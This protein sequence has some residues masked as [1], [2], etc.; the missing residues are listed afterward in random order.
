MKLPENKRSDLLTDKV[1]S[2]L[3]NLILHMQTC[4]SG[5]LNQRFNSCS[6]QEKKRL[7]VIIGLLSSILL[8][9]GSFCSLYTI[10]KLS[11]NYSS[12]HIGMPSNLPKPHLNERQ[13]TDSLT[14][15]K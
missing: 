8:I 9:A 11:Q 12:A 7:T 3:A 1:A 13:L 5:W 6:T 14:K 2:I 15:K 4:S 10:P